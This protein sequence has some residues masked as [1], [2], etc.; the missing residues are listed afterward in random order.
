M[1]I[2]F[3]KTHF[4]LIINC[5]LALIILVL[6]LIKKKPVFNQI[7]QIKSYI[8]EKLPGLINKFEQP[9]NGDKKKALVLNVIKLLLAQEFNF[10]DFSSIE[11]FVSDAIEDI[12]STP[13]K[14]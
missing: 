14:K 7:D 10:Y 5:L 2:D 6:T 11:N 12:L 4:D 3:I 13:I 9:G 1:F 8:L